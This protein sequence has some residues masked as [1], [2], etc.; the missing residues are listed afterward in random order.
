[1]AKSAQYSYKPNVT[2]STCALIQLVQ[3]KVSKPTTCLWT[4]CS[5]H[6]H[7]RAIPW[8]ASTSDFEWE[9]T[10]KSF[11]SH[12]APSCPMT[13]SRHKVRLH[14]TSHQLLGDN[15]GISGALQEG[16]NSVLP[17]LTFRKMFSDIFSTPLCLAKHW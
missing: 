13:R 17:G 15:R 12:A 6:K 4:T 16:E 1:M 3:N 8:Y 9:K 5:S 10:S 7:H 2:R 11:Q 14:S